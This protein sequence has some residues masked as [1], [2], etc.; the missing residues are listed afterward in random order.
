MR[1]L[2]KRFKHHRNKHQRDHPLAISDDFLAD[3]ILFGA[4]GAPYLIPFSS[5]L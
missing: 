1:T 3:V 4:H 5:S 2:N